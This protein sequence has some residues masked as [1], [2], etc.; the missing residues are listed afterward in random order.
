MAKMKE[1]LVKVNWHIELDTDFF[2]VF[3]K[4]KAKKHIEM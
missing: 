3:W 2:I 4:V 1:M